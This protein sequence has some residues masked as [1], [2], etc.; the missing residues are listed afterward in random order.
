MIDLKNPILIISILPCHSFHTTSM[1]S[2]L[3]VSLIHLYSL[4]N[5]D[6]KD[7]RTVSYCSLR[8][9]SPFLAYSQESY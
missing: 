8:P 7:T 2:N 6:I 1:S 5:D 9:H 4:M 3:R